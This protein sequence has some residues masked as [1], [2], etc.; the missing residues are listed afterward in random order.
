MLQIALAEP[1]GPEVLTP[2]QAAVPQ[3]GPGEILLRVAAAGVNRPDVLQRMGLYPAPPDVDWEGPTHVV[4]GDGCWPCD[5]APE[6]LRAL[7]KG[8]E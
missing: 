6:L 1:G 3:P 7:D 2:E 5:A 4:V 8:E